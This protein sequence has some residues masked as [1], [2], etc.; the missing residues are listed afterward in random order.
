MQIVVVYL[1]PFRRNSQLKCALQPKIAKKFTKTLL[2]GVQGRSRSS[3]LTNLKSTS[4]VLVMICSKSVPICN[5]FHTVR[6]NSGKIASFLGGE[7]CPTL[8]PSFEKNLINQ[9]HEILILKLE[10]LEQPKMK[11]S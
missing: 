9:G 3:T 1:Q 6:A 7:K 10:F 4:P 8:M 11:I 5:H 2:L